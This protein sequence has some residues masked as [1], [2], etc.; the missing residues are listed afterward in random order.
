MMFLPK[1]WL[2]Y[3]RL[4]TNKPILMIMLTE[5]NVLCRK[6]DNQ[7]DFDYLLNEL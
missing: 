7:T 6:M 4:T 5:S 1:I 2:N 3:A